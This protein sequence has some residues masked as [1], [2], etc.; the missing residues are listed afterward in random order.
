MCIKHTLYGSVVMSL[1]LQTVEA[2]FMAEGL[3]AV[4]HEGCDKDDILD[5]K[6]KNVNVGVFSWL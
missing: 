6:S 2:C 5:A 4:E 3:H 1:L